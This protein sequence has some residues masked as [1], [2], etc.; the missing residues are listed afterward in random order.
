VRILDLLISVCA[1][2]F[3]MY[4]YGTNYMS[5]AGDQLSARY[6]TFNTF[7]VIPAPPRKDVAGLL[8]ES[9]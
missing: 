3:P 9:F 7:Q 5:T 1:Q 4:D 6:T 2:P 8:L